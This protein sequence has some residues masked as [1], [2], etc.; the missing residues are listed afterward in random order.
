MFSSCDED[1]PDG[2][3]GFFPVQGYVELCAEVVDF[4]LELFEAGEVYFQ[5]VAH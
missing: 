1:F 4:L 2:H 3:F 5:F